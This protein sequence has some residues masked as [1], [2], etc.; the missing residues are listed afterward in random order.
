MNL[1]SYRKN[2]YSQ[3]GEDGGIEEVLNRLNIKKGKFV[4]FGAWDGVYLSNTYNLLKNK[5]WQGFFIEGD[6]E[7]YKEL[8]KLKMNHSDKLF[9]ANEFVG[10]EGDSKL[11]F[12]IK[13]YTNFN[14]DF[15]LLSVD[16]DSFDYSVWDA[17][18]E[19]NP[20]IVIIEINSHVKPPTEQMHTPSDPSRQGSSF[21]TMLK[22]GI[23]KGYTLICHTGN[24]IFIRNDKVNSI[25]LEEEYLKEPNKIFISF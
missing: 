15:E 9:I 16:I 4:E 3:N 14:K 20:I 19:Y 11:D 22:L 18:K 17:T 10:F 25:N 7:K 6:R 5:N 21:S 8:E 1:L 12:L 23:S 24:L 2:I 13:K